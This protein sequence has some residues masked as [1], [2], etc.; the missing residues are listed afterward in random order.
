MAQ[1]AAVTNLV[2]ELKKGNLAG[3][4]A[5]IDEKHGLVTGEYPQA[6]SW[7]DFIT[8]K[9]IPLNGETK[10]PDLK[11]FVSLLHLAPRITRCMDIETN[12]AIYRVGSHTQLLVAGM[13]II[14][15]LIP[16]TH[17][18]LA[19]DPTLKRRSK[20][21][22]ACA[23]SELYDYPHEQKHSARLKSGYFVAT[24]NKAYEA[25]GYLREAATKAGLRWGED[26]AVRLAG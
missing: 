17:K 13:D 14:E 8:E 15:D 23:H 19:E 22:I 4:H 9:L 16:G 25:K 1:L 12:Y 7:F 11:D 24:N 18:K 3:A 20:R 10:Q 6:T 21:F 5:W 2:E 26:F